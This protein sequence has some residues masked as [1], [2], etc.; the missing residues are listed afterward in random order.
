MQTGERPAPTPEMLARRRRM[1]RVYCWLYC[2]L[3]IA[4]AVAGVFL[5]SMALVQRSSFME[6]LGVF[7]I[8]AGG[9]RIWL[10]T[11]RMRVAGRRRMGRQLPGG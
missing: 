10:A 11:Y 9:V 5:L 3:G 4:C 1:F 2:G 6:F 8:F 7:L